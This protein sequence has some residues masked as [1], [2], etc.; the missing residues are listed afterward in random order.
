MLRG[1]PAKEERRYAT[2]L[3]LDVLREP[4]TASAVGKISTPLVGTFLL[5]NALENPVLPEV[6]AVE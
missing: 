6:F 3:N 4:L 2:S 5:A 1:S